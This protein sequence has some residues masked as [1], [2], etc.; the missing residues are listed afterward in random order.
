MLVEV[1]ADELRRF[2]GV[3]RASTG[4]VDQWLLDVALEQ[5]VSLVCVQYDVLGEVFGC[6]DV[7]SV[8]GE[9]LNERVT[10]GF[11]WGNSLDKRAIRPQEVYFHGW[12]CLMSSVEDRR[13]GKQSDRLRESLS[14]DEA[15]TLF[16][17]F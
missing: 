7:L 4:L 12:S 10:L 3:G 17:V 8:G 1:Q 6:G 14:N 15:W 11:S 5:A 9:L 2:V 13:G 16:S